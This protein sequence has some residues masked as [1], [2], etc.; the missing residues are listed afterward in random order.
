MLCFV[1]K[2]EPNSNKYKTKNGKK[3]TIVINIEFTIIN[4][5]YPL[6]Y[7]E[8]KFNFTCFHVEFKLEKKK[9][10]LTVLNI[11]IKVQ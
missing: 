9:K 8:R 7:V 1:N 3:T 4:R 10:R 6:C 2:N 5:D 11:A